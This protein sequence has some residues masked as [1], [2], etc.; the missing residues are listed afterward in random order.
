VI[1]LFTI[2]NT[3]KDNATKTGLV[4][5]FYVGLD[6]RLGSVY[7]ASATVSIYKWSIYA[8]LMDEDC[9]TGP[10]LIATPMPGRQLNRHNQW[11]IY[12]DPTSCHTSE[13]RPSSDGSWTRCTHLICLSQ[14][15]I[16]SLHNKTQLWYRVGK[17]SSHCAQKR[18][19]PILSTWNGNRLNRPY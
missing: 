14:G 8:N 5:A 2:S 12:D 15:D 13:Y 11:H 18:S 3:N 10:V 1:C 6:Y 19:T 17:L 7:E 16:F 4:E 9:V